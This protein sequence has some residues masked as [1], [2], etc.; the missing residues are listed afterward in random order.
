MPQK[1]KGRM[2]QEGQR[3]LSKRV[4]QWRQKTLGVDSVPLRA[5]ITLG[6]TLFSGCSRTSKYPDIQLSYYNF[7]SFLLRTF[8][9]HQSWTRQWTTNKSHTISGPRELPSSRTNKQTFKQTKKDNSRRAVGPLRGC[10]ASRRVRLHAGRHV[11][12]W[13]LCALW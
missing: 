12:C 11:L 13:V 3:H 4:F 8:I 9:M 2:Y 7:E 6:F 1:F 5:H 10:S